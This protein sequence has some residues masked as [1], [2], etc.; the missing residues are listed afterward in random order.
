VHVAHMEARQNA[1]KVL[2]RE[3]EGTG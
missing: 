1:Y 3:P 2:V